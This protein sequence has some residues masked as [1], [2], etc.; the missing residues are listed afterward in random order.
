MYATVPPSA[1][2]C[3]ALRFTTAV[4]PV[5]SRF[6][7]LC[8][9]HSPLHVELRSKLELGESSSQIVSFWAQCTMTANPPP[10]N[11]Q[12]LPT[13]TPPFLTKLY[14][15]VSDPNTQ[16]LV[17]WTDEKGLSFTV[18]KPSE[19]G[20]DILPKYFKH[21]NFSSFVRQLNQY[22]FHKQ[23]PDKW[24]FGHDSFRRD[25]PDLL[26]NITRRRP[27]QSQS[28][29]AVLPTALTQNAVVELG[30]Y[31]LEGEVKSLKRD[32]D[33]LI[34]ELVVT[35]Q[36]EEQLKNR[37]ENLETRVVSLENSS[38]QMQAFIMHYFSQ[39][40]QP[41]SEA[42]ASRKRKRLPSSSID[43]PDTMIVEPPPNQVANI[44]HPTG[45]SSVDALRVMMQQMGVGIARSPA[46][47]QAQSPARS[48]AQPRISFEP[49]T[50]QEL[51]LDESLST[52]S[53]SMR[54]MPPNANNTLAL[55]HPPALTVPT[56]PTPLSNA[57]NSS[58]M[59]HPPTSITQQPK[60]PSP[61]LQPVMQTHSLSV[62]V[63]SLPTSRR[64][65]RQS[66]SSDTTKQPDA[67]AAVLR[68][69]PTATVRTETTVSRL[70][71][72]P[73][74]NGSI[75]R[76]RAPRSS[77]SVSRTSKTST[78]NGAGNAN[79]GIVSLP[80]VSVLPAPSS[81]ARSSSATLSDR[82]DSS[83]MRD[84]T[85]TTANGTGTNVNDSHANAAPPAAQHATRQHATRQHAR[86][87]PNAVPSPHAFSAAYQAVSVQPSHENRSF[88]SP[89]SPTA[90]LNTPEPSHTPD[91]GLANIDTPMMNGVLEETLSPEKLFSTEDAHMSNSV[92][93]T[94]GAA[95]QGRHGVDPDVD[96]ALEFLEDIPST[97]NTSMTMD[98]IENALQEP[99][100]RSKGTHLDTPD[101]DKAFDDKEFNISF[102]HDPG[103]EKLNGNCTSSAE[104]ERVIE[105]FLELSAD[106]PGLPPPLT[107][108]PEGTDIH[109]LAKKIESFA[110][111]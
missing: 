75:R 96:R 50:V 52:I 27:K 67:A 60:P 71:A 83:V 38:K 90:F 76:V 74:A 102:G 12:A 39:V 66:V 10:R 86:R 57:V 101:F 107:H 69:S 89:A 44:S 26:K 24:M 73:A 20:R 25:R 80:A 77:A 45:R 7:L 109:A 53:P 37:C 70:R 61:S 29:N 22:G 55:I 14:Q 110:D 91:L 5:S 105:D 82:V 72:A 100:S 94:L 33:L 103:S 34:K 1:R 88:A 28:S 92:D 54:I 104:N 106:D 78:P 111:P 84:N 9:S 48:H 47:S 31:G 108:L 49:A 95:D 65:R 18:H 43:E 42:M 51:P 35:R 36:K 64:P 68:T 59:P 21:N 99:R 81:D 2:L 8:A 41:Y 46:Q 11:P 87:Q 30:N 16:P 32:K 58:T 4:A 98:V 17:S 85:P 23:N 40:L 56:S 79:M 3:G 62:P 15:L 19:F 6:P 63:P 93:V 13:Q 97:P